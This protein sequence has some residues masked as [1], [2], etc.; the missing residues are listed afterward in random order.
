MRDKLGNVIYHVWN[1]WFTISMI[2]FAVLGSILA[3][4]FLV[5]TL[6]TSVDTL[7]IILDITDYFTVFTVSSVLSIF[8]FIPLKVLF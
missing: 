1:L 7:K 2:G 3:V 5:N 8:V 4:L 6:N